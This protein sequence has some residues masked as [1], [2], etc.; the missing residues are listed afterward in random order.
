M[1]AYIQDVIMLVGDSIT[2]RGFIPNGFAQKLSGVCLQSETGCS[3]PRTQPIFEKEVLTKRIC[4]QFFAKQHEQQHVP[5]VRL[6]TIWYGANDSCIPPS[7][8][9]VPLPTFI[10][11]VTTLVR[12]VTSPSSPHYSP[13]TRIILITPPPVN[14]HQRAADLATRDPPKLLD[15]EFEVTRQYAEAVKDVGRKEQVPVVDMWTL[16]WDAS[17][18]VEENLSEFLEDGLHLNVKGYEIVYDNLIKTI[19]EHYPE[20]HYDNLGTAFPLHFEIDHSNLEASLQKRA[21]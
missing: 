12:K 17:G 4:S 9:H 1:A 14:T 18:H 20:L 8:Q 11:N 6:L 2:Q 5:K 16:L 19:S 13:V 7:I 21:V 15:R 10:T 3:Q